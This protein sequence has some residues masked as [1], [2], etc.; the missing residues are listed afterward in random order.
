LSTKDSTVFSIKCTNCAAP[1]K[2]LGGGR[3]TTVTCEYCNSVLDMTDHYKVVSQFH[4][5]YRPPVPFTLGMQ[6]KIKNVEW[7]IIGWVA[8][9]TVDFPI[10][11]WSEFFLYSPLYGYGWLIYEEGDL[12]FSKRVRDFPL[13]EWQ[14]KGKPKT[15][16]YQKGHYLAAE[17]PYSVEIDFVQGELTWIAKADDK[18]RCWDYNGVNRKS[19]SIEKS[20]QEAEVY[21]NEKLDA[22]Q[23]YQSFGVKEENRVKAK[24]SISDTLFEGE[25]LDETENN[26]STFAKWT[27]GLAALLFAAIIL[28]FFI[29]NTLVEDRSNQ[30]FVQMFTVSSDAFLTQIAIK[31]P[32]PAALDACRLTLYKS[33]KKVLSIDKHDIFPRNAY[34]GFTWTQGDDEAIIYIK[35]DEGLYRISLE[36]LKPIRLTTDKKIVVTVKE[37]F[38]R[39]SYIVPVFVILLLM[40]L[41]T[42][43]RNFIPQKQKKFFWWGLAALI[44]FLI[45]GFGIVIFIIVFY[46]FVQPT[47]D[48]ISKEKSR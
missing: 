5:K 13:R 12:S 35:L 3:V 21:L 8:Y 2:I 19:L 34:F 14:D 43:K 23:V 10:E 15:V 45:F 40:L 9:K 32:T 39:L 30:P 25:S 31:A 7:T 24:Q 47:I 18:I 20:K 41:P 42:I 37:K 27:S 11:R 4:H 1:L 38:M 16:F 36:H 46:F 29:D 6:G 22:S 48:N 28:S 33:D 17:D 26:F 44:G